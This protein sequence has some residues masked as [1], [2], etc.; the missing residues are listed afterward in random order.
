MQ[1]KIIGT[2]GTVDEE[3][4][5]AALINNPLTFFDSPGTRKAAFDKDPLTFFDASQP[6]GAWVGLDLGV[7]KPI[8]KIRFLARNDMNSICIGNNYELFY[9]DGKW[10]SLGRIKADNLFLIYHNVPENSILSL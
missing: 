10:I 4:R 9:W 5:E 7:K 2:K 8:N 1:G 6:N 3:T